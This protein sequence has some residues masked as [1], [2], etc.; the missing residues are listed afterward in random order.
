MIGQYLLYYISNVY[1]SSPLVYGY[2]YYYCDIISSYFYQTIAK[3]DIT[4]VQYD[5]TI[6]VPRQQTIL[7]NI[8][9]S[10]CYFESVCTITEGH[11]TMNRPISIEYLQ[12]TYNKGH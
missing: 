2:I 11:V 4:I 7:E 3:Y 9:Q 10:V 1:D 6:V 12:L 5:V 8:A